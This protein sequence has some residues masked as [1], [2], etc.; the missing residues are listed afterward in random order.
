[1]EIL[2]FSYLCKTGDESKERIYGDGI[3]QDFI[4]M[5]SR[6]TKTMENYT[7]VAYNHIPN[8]EQPPN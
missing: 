3:K 1:M 6:A 2:S 4:S 5:Q 7:F 8:V